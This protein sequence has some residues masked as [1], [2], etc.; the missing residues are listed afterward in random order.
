MAVAGPLAG[1]SG[2]RRGGSGRLPATYGP[3]FAPSLAVMGAVWE[4]QMTRRAVMILYSSHTKVCGVAAWIEMLHAELSY[5]GWDVTVGVT[6]GRTYHQPRNFEEGRSWISTAR[7][8][9]RTGTEEGRVQAIMRAVRRTAPDVLVVT[10]LDSAFEAIRRLR[11]CGSTFR[12]VAVNHGTIPGQAA[13][14][15]EASTFR[16]VAISSLIRCG[17]TTHLD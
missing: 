15:I 3:G 6:Q 17:S 11:R 12:T 8:D 9:G 13:C 10:C 1:G 14:L 5:A 16:R 7:M 4:A 2:K